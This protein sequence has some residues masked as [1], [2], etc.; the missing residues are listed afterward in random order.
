MLGGIPRAHPGSVWKSART[1]EQCQLQGKWGELLAF[2]LCGFLILLLLISTAACFC[3]ILLLSSHKNPFGLLKGDET[4]L[5]TYRFP[6]VF[7]TLCDPMDCSLL[8]FS[9]HRDSLTLAIKLTNFLKN[10]MLF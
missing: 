10:T 9:V 8:G 7:P 5:F 6:N 3:R 2:A 4:F 1:D